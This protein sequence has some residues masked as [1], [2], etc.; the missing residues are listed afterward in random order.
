VSRV[1]R[2]GVEPTAGCILGLPIWFVTRLRWQLSRE[3]HWCVELATVGKGAV[4][5]CPAM[6]DVY[7]DRQTAVSSLKGLREDVNGGEYD[8]LLAADQ[9]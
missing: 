9:S 1:R 7:P 8:Y 4:F 3:K 6:S 5:G 2:A